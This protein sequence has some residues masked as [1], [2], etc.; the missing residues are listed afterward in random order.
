M[1]R[2]LPLF[3]LLPLLPGCQLL[4][5]AHRDGPAAA[6]TRWQGELT[7]GGQGWVFQPCGESRR[8]QL[9]EGIGLLDEARGLLANSGA[10]ALYLDLRARA[11]ASQDA[12]F[13]GRLVPL[14]RHRLEAEGPGCR[15]ARLAQIAWRASGHHPDWTLEIARAGLLLQ[16][17]GEAPRAQPYL[18]EQL[19]D[20]QVSYSSEANGRRLE[21]W[22]APQRCEDG[23]SG[24]LS[25][26]SATLVQDG[27]RWRGC[28]YPG[29]LKP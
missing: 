3:V 11:D 17:P 2:L 10:S 13:A 21:L 22:I 28:A 9:A 24:T 14:E 15:D 5:G 6:G 19:P 27:Q 4:P 12:A 8:F 26:Y 23:A 25:A 29:G 16:T 1:R 20:G 7:L 18:A